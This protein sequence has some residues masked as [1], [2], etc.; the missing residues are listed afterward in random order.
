[1]RTLSVCAF[2]FLMTGC[3]IQ[4]YHVVPVTPA[5]TAAKLETR[6]LRDEGL[7][8]FITTA[9]GRPVTW[10]PKQ[11]DFRLL[12]LAAFYFNPGLALARDQVET[13]RAGIRT[14]EMRPNPV[15]TFTPGIPSPYL[16]GLGLAFPIVTA[17]KRGYEIQAAKNVSTEAELNL[18]EM[19]WTVRGNVRSALLN[20]L[21]AERDYGLSQLLER[22]RH[23]RTARLSVELAAGEISR[24]ELETARVALLDAQTAGRTAEARIAHG[25]AVLAAAIGIP[26]AALDGVRLDW[27]DFENLPSLSVLTK[28]KIRRDAVLNRL[29]VRRAL[30]Q[31]RAA[32]FGLKLEIARQ[33]PNFQ[34]G[35]G[36]QY[37]EQKSYF[38][39][40]ISLNLPI[41]NRNQGPIAQ[42]KA[43]RKQAAAHLVAVQANALA[44]C[45]QTL[46]QY[47]GDFKV[48]QTAQAA[49]ANFSHVQ[50]PMTSRAVATGESDR[51]ALNAVLLQS[52]AA[53][54]T[55][56]DSVFQAQVA[57]GLLEDA[58]QKPLEPAD[59][60]P[61]ILPSSR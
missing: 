15:L 38:T 50:V 34:L 57:L 7:R 58:V 25:R 1:M 56:I 47:S 51:L 16:I 26:A 52:S 59:A 13:A 9:L 42:A 61:M 14:A 48:L 54:K 31:Y 20:Y 28:N 22:L 46:A 3:A 8:Q 19:A 55:W 12:T 53:E 2:A 32:Q 24:P 29:D 4:R 27:P 5:Q 10:P 35:P 49:R 6:T 40:S 41:F 37:E 45:E 23:A 11:W 44:Q 60:T 18:A 33:F 43:Q 39:P 21:R 17:G 36:Y 30:A